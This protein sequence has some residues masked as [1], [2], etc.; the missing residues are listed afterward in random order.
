MCVRKSGLVCMQVCVCERERGFFSSD[1]AAVLTDVSM[2]QGGG[3][4]ACNIL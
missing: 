3:S 1:T 4:I 2:S